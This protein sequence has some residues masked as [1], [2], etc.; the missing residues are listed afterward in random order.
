M[1]LSTYVLCLKTVAHNVFFQY[2]CSE[3]HQYFWLPLF[4]QSE[5]MATSFYSRD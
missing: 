3:Q 5:R 1:A 4:I 2:P